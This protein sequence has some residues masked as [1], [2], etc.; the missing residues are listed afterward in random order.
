[1]NTQPDQSNPEGNIDLRVRIMRILWIALC[2][3]IVVYYVLT[4][5]VGRNENA[6]PNNTLSLTLMLVAFS[7]TV[8]SLVI[9]NKLVSRAI[10]QQQLGMVQQAY[11]VTWAICEVG[12]LMGFLDFFVTGNRYYYVPFLIAA[13]GQLLHYP[14]REHVEQASFKRTTF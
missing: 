11:V 6:T 4:I 9:K 5:V 3:S 12:A 13:A 1:M 8:I 14:R 2:L 7:T 10:D